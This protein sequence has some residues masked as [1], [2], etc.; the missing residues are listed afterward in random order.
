MATITRLSVE[1][2]GT[3]RA[4]T[5]EELETFFSHLTNCDPYMDMIF[6]EVDPGGWKAAGN[7]ATLF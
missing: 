2:D 4:D 7:T 1:A 3:E 6:T 5:P